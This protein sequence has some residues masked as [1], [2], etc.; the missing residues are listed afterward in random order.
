MLNFDRTRSLIDRAF[1][2]DPAI[3]PQPSKK[4]NEVVRDF[5]EIVKNFT[6]LQKIV[7]E[8]SK[9]IKQQMKGDSTEAQHLRDAVEQL[10]KIADSNILSQLQKGKA[11]TS[12]DL[13]QFIGTLGSIEDNLEKSNAKIEMTNKDVFNI[14][15]EA[16]NKQSSSDKDRLGAFQ[17]LGISLE[18]TLNQSIS[19]I[20]ETIAK[21]PM[22]S[23]EKAFHEIQKERMSELVKAQKELK[24]LS[25][26]KEFSEEHS[27]KISALIDRLPSEVER[28]KSDFMMRNLADTMKE[29]VFST[30]ERD[31]INDVLAKDPNFLKKALN[32]SKIKGFGDSAGGGLISLALEGVGLS[33]IDDIAGGRLSRGIGGGIRGGARGLGKVA[34]FGG[35]GIASLGAKGLA[36]GA[37]MIGSAGAGLA[38]SGLGG[39][40]LKGGLGLAKFAGPVGLALAAG[41]AAYGGVKGYRNAGQHFGTDK[42]TMGQKASSALGGALSSLSFGMLDAGKASRGIHSIGSKISSGEGMIGKAAKYGLMGPMGMMMNKGN[43]DWVKKLIMGFKDAIKEGGQNLFKNLKRFFERFDPFRML[44]TMGNTVLDLWEWLTGKFGGITGAV[45][46]AASGAWEWGKG[47]GQGVLNKAKSVADAVSSKVTGKPSQKELDAL[48]QGGLGTLSAKYESGGAGAGAV[49]TGRGDAGGASYGKFQFSSNR[50]VVQ[51]FLG[52]SQYGSEFAGLE[53]GTPAFNKKWKELAERDPE[54]FLKD[55]ERF[56]AKEYMV[57]VQGKFRK[58]GIDLT[59]R[60]KALQEVAFSTSIQHGAGGAGN[61]LSTIAAREGDLSGKTDEELID[62]IYKERGAGNGSKYFKSSSASVQQSVANRFIR[63]SQDAQMMLAMERGGSPVVGTDPTVNINTP[64]GGNVPDPQLTLARSGIGGGSGG[65]QVPLRPT[66]PQGEG[67]VKGKSA[68]IPKDINIPDILL[69][70]TALDFY[71]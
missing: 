22:N 33:G 68:P 14:I 7:E 5:K 27:A 12:E 57:P 20:G 26:I 9:L 43:R 42:A 65:F 32:S 16:M 66:P 23:E 60:S 69:S 59:Q 10:K 38:S 70:A 46:D 63:E 1:K 51:K 41:Q 56:A 35:R 21:T 36:A 8:N 3:R 48:T 71:S 18:K 13:D 37:G 11:V 34:R 25:S 53:P 67:P 30:K 28:S 62:L 45:S 2:K 4:Q 40:L 64:S 6:R 31:N 58:Q 55:Q 61:I 17:T 52:Q 49:S 47:V 19:E 24:S 39:A 54:G 50:G 44:S 29:G 15:Q